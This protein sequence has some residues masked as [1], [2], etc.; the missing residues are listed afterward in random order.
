MPPA[1]ERDGAEGAAHVAAHGDPH[2][3][4]GLAAEGTRGASART[5]IRAG[6]PHPRGARVQPEDHSHDPRQLPCATSASIL[7][8]FVRSSAP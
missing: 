1:H 7:G 4:V 5:R 2:V 8:I 6:Q 3:G